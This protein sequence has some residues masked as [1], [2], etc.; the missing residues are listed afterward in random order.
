MSFGVM[1]KEIPKLNAVW[2]AA[3]P[4]PKNAT[5][6]Q[7]IQWHL[8]HHKNCTCREIPEKL[9]VEIRKRNLL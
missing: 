5:L 2:H 1:E 3:H 8:E 9:M 7:R 6:E 4:M